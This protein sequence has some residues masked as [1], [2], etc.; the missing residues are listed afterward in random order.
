MAQLRTDAGAP[1]L[2]ALEMFE[3]LLKSLL[4]ETQAYRRYFSKG[5]LES[6]FRRE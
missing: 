4:E 3:D 6:I 2:A 5:D 1:D